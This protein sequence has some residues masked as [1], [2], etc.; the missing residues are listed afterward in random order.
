MSKWNK[1]IA[2]RWDDASTEL[3]NSQSNLPKTDN[4]I[5]MPGDESS[6]GTEVLTAP[7]LHP[8]RPRALTIAYNKKT[9]V[10]V[11]VFRDGTWWQYNDIPIGVWEGLKN[12]GSTGGYLPIIENACSSH[13]PAMTKDFAAATKEQISYNAATAKRIQDKRLPTLEETLFGKTGTIEPRKS[14]GVLPNLWE[15]L[16]GTGAEE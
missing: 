14:G 3:A 13:G 9:F 4:D 16:F 1:K 15:T 8:E 12:A 2:Q 10:L 6:A 11:I 5:E 7:T